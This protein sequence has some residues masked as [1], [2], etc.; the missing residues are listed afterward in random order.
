MAGGIR[1]FKT[2]HVTEDP[3]PEKGHCEETAHPE[4]PHD[5]SNW[6]VSYA[7][8]MTLL[9][10][11]FVMLFSM[12]KLNQPEYEKVKKAVAEQFG[13][14]YQAPT[15]ELTKFV[16]QIIEELGVAQETVVTSDGSGVSIAFQSLVFFDTLSSEV[17]PEGRIILNKLIESI[18]RRQETDKK[19][20]KIVVEGHTDSRPIV[21]GLYPSNWELSGA[22]AARVVRMFLDRGFPSNHLVAIGYADTRPEVEARSPSG[23]LS[24]ELLAKNR[25]VVIR[26]L[27]PEVEAIPLPSSPAT[28]AS[29]AH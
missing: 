7:D 28:T 6:L 24:G 11:F 1:K 25:R 9:C 16:T 2:Q 18:V 20:Y 26:I 3:H 5:E 13:G 4:A 21:G 23:V 12:A 29:S 27:E 14:H 8:M 15:E 10:G 19:A 17:K 22:R